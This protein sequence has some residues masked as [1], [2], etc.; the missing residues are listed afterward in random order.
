MVVTSA[1]RDSFIRKW[2]PL[3]TSERFSK[4]CY[5]LK[6]KKKLINKK[7]VHFV[8]SSVCSSILLQ[9]YFRL[10]N[11]CTTYLWYALLVFY[12]FIFDPGSAFLVCY[13]FIFDP[14]SELLSRGNRFHNFGKNLYSYQNNT[15][16]LNATSSRIKKIPGI[17]ISSPI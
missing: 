14:G 17:F 4:G 1:R 7:T 6:Q 8:T 15:H 12:I 11:T 5:T 13:I 3:Y 9:W 10:Q 16:S 2:D